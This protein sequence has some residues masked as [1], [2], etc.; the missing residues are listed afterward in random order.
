MVHT[1]YM[2]AQGT[3]MVSRN[4]QDAGLT[5]GTMSMI[6]LETL[7]V[8]GGWAGWCQ[9]EDSEFAIRAHAVGYRS[10]FLRRQYGFGLI[11]ENLTELKKQRFRWTYGPG[12]EFKAHARLYL[13]GWLG[14]KPSKLTGRQRLRHGHYGFLVL[15]TG[16]TV[17]SLPAGV[18]LLVSMIVHHEALPLSPVLLIPLVAVLLGRRIMRWLI[19]RTYVGTGLAEMMGGAIALMAVKPTISTAAFSVLLGKPRAL[20]A[21]EQVPDDV[22]PLALGL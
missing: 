7:D 4:E 20:A 3:E 17:L 18:A 16:S 9:T 15:V 8:A 10:I 6:R 11:P 5:V 21:Y 1:G 12:Q 2:W 13:P 19:F 14:G 22:E